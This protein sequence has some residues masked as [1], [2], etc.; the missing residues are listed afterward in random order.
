[1]RVEVLGPIQLRDDEAEVVDVPERKVRALLAALIAA[2]GETI[3]AETLI[4]RVWGEDLPS[5]PSRV[6]QA[7]L[8]QLRSLL[9]Q[10]APGAKDMLVRSPG[11]YSLQVS[12]GA[13]D[14]A[15]FREA[16][17][18]ASQLSG[19][20]RAEHLKD[21]LGL[22]R[23]AAYAEFA[24]EL[25]LMPE[26]SQLQ[27][28]RLTAVEI[29]AESLIETGAAEEAVSLAAPYF[30]QHPTRE[31]LA[32]PLLLGYYRSRRQPEA[33]AAYERLRAHLA[34]ELGVEPS[35]ELQ[36]LH[37]KILRQ[38]PELAPVVETR[39]PAGPGTHSP[40]QVSPEGNGVTS[41]GR[42]LPSYASAFFGREQELAEIQ[43]LLSHHR[44]VTL[45]GIGGIG[46]TRLA[47]R[48][49]AEFTEHT[50]TEVWFLDLSELQPRPD[51]YIACRVE[52]IYRITAETLQLTAHLSS[53]DSIASRIQSALQ[54]REAL[55]VLDN[56]EHVIDEVA[57]FTDELL[58]SAQGVRVLAT[59]RE[60]MG[61]AEEQ[62]FVVPQLQVNGETSPA[63]EFFLTRAQAV[64]SAIAR[65][66]QTVTAASEL[67]RHLDGLPLALELA[68]ART[69][70]LS[71]PDL[72][73]RIT[74]RLDLL[75]RP[76]RAAPRRQQ[77]LRGML[78]WSWSLL[79]AEEQAL[80]RRL[81]VHPVI[82]RLDVIEQVCAD[83]GQWPTLGGESCPEARELNIS[84]DGQVLLS[85]RRVLP[86]LANLVERSL[87]STI[88]VG[89]ETRYRLL[90]TVG[91]YAA[92]KLDDAGER[93]PLALKHIDYYRN[94]VD[95]AS[96]YLFGPQ[97]REWVV[98]IDEARPQIALAITEAL[99]R[100]DGASAVSLVLATFWFRWMTGRADALLE[101]LSAAAA[102]PNP[103]ESPEEKR[104]HAQVTV[105][106]RTVADQPTRL[107]VEPVLEA[108]ESFGSDEQS[109]LA[110]MEVQWF[111][112]TVMFGD[113]AHLEQ[114]L[115]LFR[116]A[117]D[118]L[119]QAGDL[120]AAAFASTQRD[121][122][123]LEVWAEPPQ[124]LPGA[125]DV[126]QILRDH[127]DSYGLTQA[128]GVQH[129][130]AE[131]HGRRAEARRLLD[132]VIDLCADLQLD[133]ELS[134]WLIVEAVLALR[135]DNDDAAEQLLARSLR[136]AH[137]AA[138]VYC[139]TL[140]DATAAILAA[141]RGDA[142]RSNQLLDG[143][144]P[145]DRDSSVRLLQRYL[146]PEQ[147]PEELRTVG[148]PSA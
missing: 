137:R 143:L 31:G 34:D 10:A 29:A 124:G 48:T 60:P 118:Y 95:C 49:A 91:T 115:E 55:L 67:C 42:W 45:L 123:L 113:A 14:A 129:L 105:L 106:A 11:G 40:D 30:A 117:I 98:T 58:R 4:D 103:S 146:S 134:F 61:L 120:R 107:K 89:G 126:E 110:R 147:I 81:A 93:D 39:A 24:D 70:V 80:L 5:N 8:S 6:L 86:V 92:E 108:L 72:L 116:E 127:G 68:A 16:V 35:A 59:S 66:E 47:V 1:M 27:Q 79:E 125:L 69:S 132:E 23:G 28:E 121:W 130:W 57:T 88:T 97:A 9:E 54:A 46:K 15:A 50:Q 109:Q 148:A 75:A 87:V 26:V 13:S 18:T 25:W 65:D 12:A 37:L 90:E 2:A 140:H 142:A 128:L 62:R 36:D 19:A 102:C 82:W 135:E 139:V 21:A 64:N 112:A 71:V 101:E 145:E 104:A 144:S 73:D 131:T 94:L 43:D 53:N 41:A 85:R 17:Q 83:S 100:Q 111:G 141:K 99:R 114:G 136:L 77:T 32:A 119:I 38:D 33:L 84:V 3:S 122:F 96:L 133:G 138:Y 7:K 74:D 78:D 22:W 76:G 20:Q 51:D 52:R 56:C 44:L 63:V